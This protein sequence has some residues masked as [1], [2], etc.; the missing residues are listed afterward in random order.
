LCRYY[1]LDSIRD[2]A[3]ACTAAD[4]G[5]GGPEGEVDF[6]VDRPF[7]F[8]IVS[9]SGQPLFAGVVNCPAA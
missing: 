5:A 7:L 4:W 6:A 8:A 1:F 2:I 9:D 3:A